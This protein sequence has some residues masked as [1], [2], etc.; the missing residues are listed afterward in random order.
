MYDFKYFLN[1]LPISL[2]QAPDQIS[3]SDLLVMV[4]LAAN[5]RSGLKNI[6][7]LRGLKS[8]LS[9]D[10]E[11]AY[12]DI[13]ATDSCSRQVCRSYIQV[14]QLFF[15]ANHL[16]FKRRQRAKKRK[17]Q[18]CQ[19]DN[20]PQWRAGPTGIRSLCNVCGL[21]Y[22]KRQARLGTMQRTARTPLETIYQPLSGPRA[23]AHHIGVRNASDTHERGY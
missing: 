5:I 17:C 3:T 2:D 19:A 1:Q 18:H 14:P 7:A 12:W 20:T 11:S 21:L 8:A 9:L 22:M 15:Q 4:E 6:F 10:T 13:I 23:A 16:C